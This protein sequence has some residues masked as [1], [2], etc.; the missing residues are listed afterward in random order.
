MPVQNL[1]IEYIML[2]PISSLIINYL[3]YYL[4]VISP[5]SNVKMNRSILLF[6]VPIHLMLSVLG[7]GLWIPYL[8][9]DIYAN[10]GWSPEHQ[11]KA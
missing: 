10:S 2:F 3:N 6:N 8:F 11:H 9:C 7:E 4:V 1:N 5:A